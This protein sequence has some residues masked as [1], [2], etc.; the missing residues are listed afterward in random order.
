MKNK[1]WRPKN[2]KIWPQR[3][4]ERQPLEHP[5]ACFK[6]HGIFEHH[7]EISKMFRFFH[8][9]AKKSF[10]SLKEDVQEP[11]QVVEKSFGRH[12]TRS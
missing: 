10:Y 9:Y 8:F 4:T 6:N 11:S 3:P 7:D 2:G 1:I 12:Y 5:A